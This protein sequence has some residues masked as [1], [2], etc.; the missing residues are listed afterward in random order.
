MF[1]ARSICW[2]TSPKKKLI[3]FVS[4]VVVLALEVS[5]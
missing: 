3:L 5:R 2:P 4:V 1:G